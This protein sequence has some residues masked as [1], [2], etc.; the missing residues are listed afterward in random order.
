MDNED[1]LKEVIVRVLKIDS[2]GVWML[3]PTLYEACAFA[4]AYP[5][6]VRMRDQIILREAYKHLREKGTLV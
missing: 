1:K 6:E 2:D 3:I 5:E 4:F